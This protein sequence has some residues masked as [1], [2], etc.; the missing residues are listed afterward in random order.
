MLN[1]K[2][3]VISLVLHINYSLFQGIDQNTFRDVMHNT[4]DLV[5]EEAILERIWITWE[6]GAAGGEGAL[7]FESWVR[8]LSVLLKG[9]EEERRKHCFNVYDLNADGFITRDEMFI[10]LK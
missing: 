10:L 7:K 6:R 8:G 2:K 1:T 4:F 9:T 5:T 3:N